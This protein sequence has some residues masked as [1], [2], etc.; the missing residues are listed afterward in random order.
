MAFTET[1]DIE[2][3]SAD[4]ARRFRGS[5]GFWMLAEQSLR[6]RQ[7]LA[8]LPDGSLVLDVGGGHAQTA[9]VL[10]TAG[11][12]VTVTGSDPVCA[13]R[14]TQSVNF[15]LADCL[16][17]PFPD[18][19]FDAVI[20]F[21]LLPHCTQWQ[22]L[23]QEMC[24][25]AQNRVVFDYPTTQSLNVVA[26][27]LFGLKK[28]LEKNTRPFTLFR[29]D[30]IRKVLETQ[31]YTVTA[32]RPQFFWPMVLHRMVKIPILSRILE[33]P[34]RVLGLTRLFG[35]PVVLEARRGK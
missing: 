7:S 2:T 3:S 28:K 27:S 29:H 23:L 33:A 5:I 32:I 12:N 4:Y 22:T 21:R 16:A 24:R 6:L 20:S 13:E 15:V 26:D 11:Y 25:V 1:A 9:P 14:L 8:G 17:L 30:D 19:S 31:G 10:A 18:R 34:C 35:S